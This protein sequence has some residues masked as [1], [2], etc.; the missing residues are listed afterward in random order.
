[1]SLA[2]RTVVGAA[3]VTVLASALA[4]CWPSQQQRMTQNFRITVEDESGR[5]LG[6]GVWRWVE[7]APQ[8]RVRGYAGWDG[9]AFPILHPTHGKMY[10]IV[11]TNSGRGG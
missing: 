9:E 8:L 2:R 7:N 6:T 3:G 5:Q 4:G 1:M 10:V 11:D